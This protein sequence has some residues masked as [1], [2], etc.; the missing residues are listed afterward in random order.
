M[1]TLYELITE[2]IEI[3]GNQRIDNVLLFVIGVISFVI[4]FDIV[5]TICNFV[6]KKDS[7]LM[8]EF[9]WG[10]RLIIFILLSIILIEFFKLI[11]WFFSFAWWVYLIIFVIIV[12]VA[13]L[14]CHIKKHVNSKKETLY[15]GKVIENENTNNEN[16]DSP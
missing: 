7:K 11:K 16:N 14:I 10:F 9:H 5:G 12:I 2:Y 8:S 13:V 15:K 6:K 1:H 3:T 4:A